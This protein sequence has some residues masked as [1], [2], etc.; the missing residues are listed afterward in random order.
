MGIFYERKHMWIIYRVT[1]IF[2]TY[3]RQNLNLWTNTSSEVDLLSNIIKSDL[4]KGSNH[5]PHRR[6]QISS[7]PSRTEYV[8]NAKHAIC[9]R[10]VQPP[11]QVSVVSKHIIV[12]KKIVHNHFKEQDCFSYIIQCKDCQF[13]E[14][15]P[16]KKTNKE[17]VTAFKPISPLRQ[18]HV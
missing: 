11:L 14:F 17:R 10:I 15:L 12:S 8:E 6:W 18:K 9:C 13:L 4:C 1:V 2:K 7:T 5:P 16:R 3:I